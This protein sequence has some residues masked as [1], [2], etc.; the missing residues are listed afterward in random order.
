MFFGNGLEPQSDM[1]M[2]SY[3]FAIVLMGLGYAVP[4][5][6]GLYLVCRNK[7]SPLSYKV[8]WILLFLCLGLITLLAYLVVFSYPKRWSKN[9]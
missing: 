6:V 5:I 9:E 2:F 1:F 8:G 4:L 3:Y 7:M